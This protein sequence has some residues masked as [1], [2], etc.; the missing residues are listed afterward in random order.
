M[1]NE[2]LLIFSM[3]FAYSMVLVFY[4]FFGKVGLYSWTA[5]LSIAANIEVLILVDAF[6]IEQTL[7]NVLF[8]SNFLVS[9]ILSEN[10]SKED[11]NRAVKIGILSSV[12]FIFISQIWLLYTPS[13]ND[14]AFSSIKE[15]FTS[16]P[17]VM[18]A[19][20]AVYAF[21]QWLDVQLY[22]ILW[23]KSKNYFGNTKRGLWFRN[24]CSTLI[25]QIFNTVL[26]TI[27][28]FYNV[29]EIEII[30]SIIISS[31]T[32]FAVTAIC[33]T[34]VVYLSRIIKKNEKS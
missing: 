3:F 30:I 2:I 20:L 5:I 24:N 13:V 19:G 29:F 17:R 27:L 31:Y 12:S 14:W 25:S 15:I 32:I 11:A 1:T 28:A 34:P 18:F 22:H 21:S 10:E 9:D 23:E 7:G 6:G 4:K 33:D 16:T 26:F 8:A